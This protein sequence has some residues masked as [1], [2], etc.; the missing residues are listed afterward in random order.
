MGDDDIRIEIDHYIQAFYIDGT[1][2][3]SE[4]A[5]PDHGLYF[6]DFDLAPIRTEK[7]SLK[8]KK[9]QIFVEDLINEHPD[10][11]KFVDTKKSEPFSVLLNQY[12]VNAKVK[13]SAIY[14]KAFIDRKVYSKIMGERDYHPSRITVISFGLALELKLP[15]MEEFLASAGYC[16]SHCSKFDLIIKYFI[17]KEIYDIT[18]IDNW[19]DQYNQTTILRS[20]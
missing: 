4:T 17:E 14:K 7:K 15:E 8:K 9:A 16:F 5:R 12:I 18:I 10:I 3:R 20:A 13:P 19:L 6:P 2:N 11:D 1:K